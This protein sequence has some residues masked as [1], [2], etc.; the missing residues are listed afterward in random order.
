MALDSPV[1]ILYDSNGVEMA[2]QDGA[3][4]PV[5]TPNLLLAGS[6]GAN[7]QTLLVDS[8]GRPIVAGAGTAGAPAGGVVTVQG[9]P[10]GT[11]IPISGSISATPT[12]ATTSATSSVASSA[13]SVTLL[14]LN[15]NRLGATVFNDSNKDLYLKLGA[16]ASLVDFTA[17]LRAGDYYEVPANY[18]GV[19]DGIWSAVNG[20]ARV[21][22]LTP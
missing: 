12:K 22:E 3:A 20:S 2:V 6:D 15:A 18:T 21:T 7:A 5:G 11:P 17:K 10:A 9:D 4:I 13:V 19:I 14:A 1:A 16:V 8:N